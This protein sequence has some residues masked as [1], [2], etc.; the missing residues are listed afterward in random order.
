MLRP[1]LARILTPLALLGLLLPVAAGAAGDAAAGKSTYST[2][3]VSCHGETGKGDGPAGAA[4]NPKP[5]DFSIGDYK[6]DA[7]GDGTA[8]TDADMALIIKNGAAKYGGSA[9]MAP[10][11][12]LSDKQIQDVVA[13]VRSLKQ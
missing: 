9:L 4:L 12:H 13:Y 6:Y 10:W 3:C 11:G 5:R 8:G 1:V 2:L 7:D